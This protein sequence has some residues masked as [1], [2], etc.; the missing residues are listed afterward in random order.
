[1]NTRTPFLLHRATGEIVAVAGTFTVAE[2]QRFCDDNGHDVEIVR[3]IHNGKH[4]LSAYPT[5]THDGQRQLAA[6]DDLS[7][8]D[9]PAAD[10]CA[11]VLIR[12]SGE[13]VAVDG[14]FTMGDVEEFCVTNGHDIEDVTYENDGAT[15]VAHS[16]K[17]SPE[18][19]ET[20]A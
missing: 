10:T 6:D 14:A 15:I 7:G 2:A 17:P 11:F 13:R 1:M 5:G 18:P 9:A 16:R 4:V 12:P 8:D 19:D 3:A 20:T